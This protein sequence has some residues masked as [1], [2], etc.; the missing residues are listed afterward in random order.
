MVQQREDRKIRRKLQ[1]DESIWSKTYSNVVSSSKNKTPVSPTKEG[2]YQLL[3]ISKRESDLVNFSPS[4][5]TD[6]FKDYSRI[7]FDNDDKVMASPE[8]GIYHSP[9]VD[10]FIQQMNFDERVIV[11]VILY[12]NSTNHKQQRDLY[13]KFATSYN[14]GTV[15]KFPELPRPILKSLKKS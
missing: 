5:L 10:L 12:G 2:N 14:D 7:D 4:A 3:G 6:D 11:G 1:S 13:K 15:I 9:L 8:F